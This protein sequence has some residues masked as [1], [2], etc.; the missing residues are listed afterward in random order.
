MLQNEI[1]YVI[2]FFK[3]AFQHFNRL[4]QYFYY[5]IPTLIVY[6]FNIISK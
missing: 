5:I 1:Q 2:V 4:V 6:Y 3:L